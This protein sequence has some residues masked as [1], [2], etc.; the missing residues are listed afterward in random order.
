MNP[1]NLFYFGAG[2]LIAVYLINC[3]IA[4]RFKRIN[5]KQAILYICAVAMMGVVGEVFVGSLYNFL[6][7]SKLWEYRVLPIHG[8]YTSYYALVIWGL[9]G[10]YLYLAHD[11]LDK[12]NI[13]AHKHLALIF[14]AEAVI[15]EIAVNFSFL[16]LFGQYIFYYFPSDLWHLTSIQTIP[17]YL[18]A[19]F[20]ISVTLK[21][22]KADPLFFSLMAASFAF[23]LV[24]LV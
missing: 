6:F 24:F 21:R 14:G 19:G 16:L 18:V 8:G 17:F 7:D 12:R 13:R 22:Y 9:M 3:I 23:V 5:I 2:W 1:F 15:L 11:T 4:K 20:I 10:F